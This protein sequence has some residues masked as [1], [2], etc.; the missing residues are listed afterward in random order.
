[1]DL[2]A[3]KLSLATLAI[4]VNS[5]LMYSATVAKRY[6]L[7]KFLTFRQV[8]K[9]KYFGSVIQFGMYVKYC[10]ESFTMDQARYAELK[11]V[12]LDI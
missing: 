3:H 7:L 9:C 4:I 1:M 12:R 11:S 8:Q 2:G 6:S 10:H 5:E